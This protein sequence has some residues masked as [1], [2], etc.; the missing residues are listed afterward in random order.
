MFGV[1][2]LHQRQSLWTGSR[3]QSGQTWLLVFDDFVRDSHGV[4]I[5]EQDINLVQYQYGQ[6]QFA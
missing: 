6:M 4:L 5:S 1:R 3:F 2:M